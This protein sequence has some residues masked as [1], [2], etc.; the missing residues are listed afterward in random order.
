MAGPLNRTKI[1]ANE[2]VLQPI[3]L[4]LNDTDLHI[5]TDEEEDTISKH[6]QSI[7]IGKVQDL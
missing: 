2:S 4:D 7:N 5:P 1:D 6:I 3:R